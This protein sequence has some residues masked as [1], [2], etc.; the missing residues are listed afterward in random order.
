MPSNLDGQAFRDPNNSSIEI[1]GWALEQL[2]ENQS[3]S[4]SSTPTDSSSS[5]SPN[6]TTQQGVTGQLKVEVGLETSLM[7]LTLHQGQVE[8][9]W[10]GQS[11]SEQFADYYHFFNYIASQYRL[12]ALGET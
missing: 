7:T 9:H 8:Y 5:Q 1:R 2:P 3:S 6:F 4:S 11:D 12:P 10:Q